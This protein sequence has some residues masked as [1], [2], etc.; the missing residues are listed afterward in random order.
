V[1]G[2]EGGTSLHRHHVRL[3]PRL[4]AMIAARRLG[5]MRSDG[6]SDRGDIDRFSRIHGDQ[7]PDSDGPVVF[8]AHLRRD[9]GLHMNG[10]ACSSAVV[11]AARGKL[12]AALAVDLHR[13]LRQGGKLPPLIR[14]MRP[15]VSFYDH[16]R[17]VSGQRP[18]Q[19]HRGRAE[20][21]GPGQIR[22]WRAEGIVQRLLEFVLADEGESSSA[23][24]GTA[25]LVLPA[26]GAPE[27]NTI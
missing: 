20:L 1:T 27:T 12:W 26:P 6:S 17:G 15:E 11:V 25:R 21:A 16:R 23:A 8:G 22:R 5:Q 7:F 13:L 18:Q 4:L 19:F 14:I 3:G 2:N 9:A 24:S 10:M